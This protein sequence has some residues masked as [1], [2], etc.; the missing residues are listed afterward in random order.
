MSEKE[1]PPSEE[2]IRKSR[3]K[4]QLGTSQEVVKFLKFVLIIEIVFGLESFWRNAL[5]EAFVNAMPGSPHTFQFKVGK[6]LEA[7]KPL[8]LSIFIL[9]LIS[10]F[11]SLAATLMQTK[12]NIASKAFEEGMQ[13]LDIVSN[14]KQLVSAKKLMQAGLGPFKIITIIFVLY[15]EILE[16]IPS[17]LQMYQSTPSQAWSVTVE[18]LH[19]LERSS[20]V[21]L[22]IWIVFDFFLQKY[23][24]LKGLRMD[25]KEVKDEYK[26]QEGDPHAK[27]HRKGIAR[28]IA[29]EANAAPPKRRAE[30]ATAVVVNPHHIAI[31]IAYD[32]SPNSLP[33]VVAKGRDIGALE[34]RE[35]AA[36]RKIPIIKFVS[37]ARQLYASAKEGENIP[38][39]LFKPVALLYQAVKEINDDTS[40]LPPGYIYELD[41]VVVHDALRIDSR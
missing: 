16:K 22:F 35:L 29:N 27:G 11:I 41:D 12:F 40:V 2:K 6:V 31:A 15:L 25:L 19:Q 28:Q 23:L 13:K 20:L 32:F 14:M 39:N 33:R 7:S 10:G 18:F 17:V 24:Y 1:L 8:F 5:A 26:E 4:G 3:E 38:G 30:G 37:L 9:S 34:L 21:V 36:D